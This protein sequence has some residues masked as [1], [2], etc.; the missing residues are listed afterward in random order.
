[1]IQLEQPAIAL[2]K[3]FGEAQSLVRGSDRSRMP[4]GVAPTVGLAQTRGRHREARIDGQSA[5]ERLARQIPLRA[6]HRLLAREE[7][8]HRLQRSRGEGSP[9]ISQTRLTAQPA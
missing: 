8:L 3:M 5:L 4:G 9:A 2:G 6:T 1:M 7:G